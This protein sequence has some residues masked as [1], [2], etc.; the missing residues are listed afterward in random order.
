MPLTT[1]SQQKIF[2]TSLAT[3]SLL[4]FALAVVSTFAPSKAKAAGSNDVEYES[5][6]DYSSNN[7]LLEELW[8]VNIF[9]A[10]ITLLIEID[11]TNSKL[12]IIKILCNVKNKIVTAHIT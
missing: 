11:R 3:L 1:L 9:I 10:L 5:V 12:D 6:L 8:Q 4:I 2:F 7:I